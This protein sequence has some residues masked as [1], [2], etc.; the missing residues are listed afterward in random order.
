MTR[1]RSMAGVRTFSV[2]ALI[3]AIAIPWAGWWAVGAVIVSVLL[4]ALLVPHNELPHRGRARL[5]YEAVQRR[6]DRSSW[7]PRSF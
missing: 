3:S 7:R 5:L 1:F 4:G 2:L 6:L